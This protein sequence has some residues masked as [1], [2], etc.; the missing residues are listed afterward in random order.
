MEKSYKFTVYISDKYY[1][2][3]DALDLSVVLSDEEHDRILEIIPKFYWDENPNASALRDYYPEMS[4]KVLSSAIPLAIEKWGDEAKIENGAKY[5]VDLPEAI[6]DEYLRT[7]DYKN[8]KDAKER[9][10]SNCEK[11]GQ[12]EQKSLLSE[13]SNGRWPH[14]TGAGPISIFG[15]YKERNCPD[16]NY[17]MDCSCMNLH[18]HYCKRYF[19]RGSNMYISF[20]GNKESGKYLVDKVLSD[21]GRDITVSDYESCLTVIVP[22]K[23]DESDVQILFKMFDVVESWYKDWR[24]RS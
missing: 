22:A 19:L 1:E 3:D 21:C 16:L 18:I 7:E 24:F 4:E 5:E 8:W 13:H 2:L 10:E 17:A 11:Q 9:M 6:E 15:R 23:E 12:Y 20:F 14:F